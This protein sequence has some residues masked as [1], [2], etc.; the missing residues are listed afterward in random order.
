MCLT[1]CDSTTRS[2]ENLCGPEPTTLTIGVDDPLV[3]IPDQRYKIDEGNQG[4]YHIDVSVRVVGRID[5]DDVNIL[6]T[7]MDTDTQLAMHRTDSWLLKIHNAGPHCE[8]PRARLVLT[9]ADDS[10]MELEDV[11]SL[12]GKTV[13]LAVDLTSPDGDAKGSFRLTLSELVR[14][15]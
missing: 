9:N 8:Y 7:L 2:S 1:A 12:V 13:D 3:E 10:L 11:E 6:M 14:Q 4:G 5:P 15:E